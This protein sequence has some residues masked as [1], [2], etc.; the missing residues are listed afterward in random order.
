[1]I[2][3]INAV[4]SVEVKFE[5]IFQDVEQKVKRCKIGKKG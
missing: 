3:I 4:K 1:M 5:Y 2:E